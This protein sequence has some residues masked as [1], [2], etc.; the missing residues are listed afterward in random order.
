VEEY[1]R[2]A[3]EERSERQEP[4]EMDMLRLPPEHGGVQ[5]ITNRGNDFGV[6]I[7]QAGQQSREDL[8]SALVAEQSAGSRRPVVAIRCR[9]ARRARPGRE[10]R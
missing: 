5:G 1:E 6:H 7:M 9:Q 3:R 10:R 8:Q 2:T 4:L